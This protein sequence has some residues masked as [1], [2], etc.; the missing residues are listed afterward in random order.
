MFMFRLGLSNLQLRSN[1]LPEDYQGEYKHRPGKKVLDC[2]T[3]YEIKDIKR[4]CD[5]LPVE[6]TL[7][8]HKEWKASL[9]Y[10]NTSVNMAEGDR[11]R[12]WLEHLAENV[13][14]T[15]ASLEDRTDAERAFEILCVA[16]SLAAPRL[17]STY[18]AKAADWVQRARAIL[19][20][21]E[22]R[23]TPQMIDDRLTEVL[24]GDEWRRV[25][26]Q[27]STV[28]VPGALEP[29]QVEGR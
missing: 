10:G 23:L 9:F 4:R 14:E 18:A 25:P 27:T 28:R 26:G 3:A 6:L 13:E 7:E 2:I 15:L 24:G 29:A 5:L 11:G 19:E 22:F 1:L 8:Q 21:P 20:R 12:A 16:E 17:D